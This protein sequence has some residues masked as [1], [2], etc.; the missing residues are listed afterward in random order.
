MKAPSKIPAILK[1]QGEECRHVRTLKSDPFATTCIYEGPAGKY[2][3]KTYHAHPAFLFFGLRFA[4]YLAR[5]EAAHYEQLRTVEGIPDPL[6]SLNAYTHVREY[7]EGRVL[8]KKMPVPDDYFDRLLTLLH[9]VHARDMVHADVE[10]PENI[11]VGT[12]GQPYLIDFQISFTRQGLRRAFGPLA[13]M[14]FERLRQADLY[15]F[16]KHKR[17]TRPDLTTP[18]EDRMGRRTGFW[19]GLHRCVTRPYFYLR[20][21]IVKVRGE[22]PPVDGHSE[23]RVD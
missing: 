16:Y 1:V 23:P 18:E 10:K 8:N 21:K 5:R 11:L 17:R 6:G 19:V 9:N 22:E 7:I 15:H 2:V 20:R 14:V 3:F 12:D 13:P 4:R